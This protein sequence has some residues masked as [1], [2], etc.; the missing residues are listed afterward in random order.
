MRNTTRS[1]RSWRT[2]RSSWG[3]GRLPYLKYRKS[4]SSVVIDDGRN[5][6][7]HTS[8]YSDGPAALYEY[9]ADA[10]TA[11]DLATRFG[12]ETWFAAALSEF[13]EK[14]LMIFL[15][16]RYLSLALPENPNL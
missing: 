1:S 10:R 7:A 3:N 2:G 6:R 14:D 16:R 4:W 8:T 5:G 11:D 12:N 15:D 9:C 13:V